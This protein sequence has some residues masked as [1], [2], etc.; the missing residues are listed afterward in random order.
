MLG[1]TKVYTSSFLDK[2]IPSDKFICKPKGNPIY[3]AFLVA[4]S[5]QY[6]FTNNDALDNCLF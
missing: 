5:H 6:P 4:F 1:S 2:G 3:K